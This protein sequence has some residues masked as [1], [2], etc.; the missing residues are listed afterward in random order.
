L[1]A[2]NNSVLK[3]FDSYHFLVSLLLNACSGVRGLGNVAQQAVLIA[4]LGR[5]EGFAVVAAMAL[6][7]GLI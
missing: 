6:L 7:L 1:N 5:W 2:G 3:C 4:Y